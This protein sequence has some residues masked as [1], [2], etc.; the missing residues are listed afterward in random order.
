M[1][2]ELTELTEKLNHRMLSQKAFQ[3]DQTDWTADRHDFDDDPANFDGD[4]A[5]LGLCWPTC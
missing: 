2:T 1:L 3:A 5:D 4:Q